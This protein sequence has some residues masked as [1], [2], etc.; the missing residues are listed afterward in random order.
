MPEETKIEEGKLVG[1]IT[2]YFGKISVAVVK[3]EDTLRVGDKIKIVGGGNEFTQ[4]VESMQIEHQ[5]VQEAKAGES[6][7]LKVLQKVKEGYKVYKL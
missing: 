1:E 5:P 2:H 4:T 6:I 7:G 3:L